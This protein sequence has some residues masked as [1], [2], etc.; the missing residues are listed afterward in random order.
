MIVRVSA[1]VDKPLT[2]EEARL[3]LEDRGMQFLVFVD[4]ETM[5]PSVLYRRPGGDYGLVQAE[6]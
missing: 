4:A 2:P 1:P 3:E 6:N 5:S